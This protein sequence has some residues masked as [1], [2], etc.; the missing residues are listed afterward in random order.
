LNEL[1]DSGILGF[2][3]AGILELRNSGMLELRDYELGNS[4]IP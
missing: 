4:R 2:W 3:N 1:G